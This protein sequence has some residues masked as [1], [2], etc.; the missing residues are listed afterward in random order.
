MAKQTVES[1]KRKVVKLQNQITALEKDLKA[2]YADK[3]RLYNLLTAT[4]TQ[5]INSLVDAGVFGEQVSELYKTLRIIKSL[6]TDTLNSVGIK[7]MEKVTK[8]VL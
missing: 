1:L 7:C 6:S 2:A 5:R 8:E 4:T 3:D